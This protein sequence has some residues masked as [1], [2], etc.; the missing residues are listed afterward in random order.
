MLS[1]QSGKVS[2]Q[3]ERFPD[4]L[5]DFWTKRMVSRQYGRF[6]DNL[7]VFQK[8]GKISGQSGNFPDILKDFQTV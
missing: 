4:I 5:E 8:F 1:V 7:E 3:S 2:G 6:Q